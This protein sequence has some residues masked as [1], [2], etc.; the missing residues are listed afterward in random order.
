MS[1]PGR[2]GGKEFV[3]NARDFRGASSVPGSG[4]SPGRGIGA[5][6]SIVSWE[7]PRTK[8]P[9]GLQPMGPQ[10]VGHD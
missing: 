10:R 2:A 7:I 5:H 9:G 6:S 1:L 4:R 8:E 3:C